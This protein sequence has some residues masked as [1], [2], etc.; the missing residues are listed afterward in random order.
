MTK[1][2]RRE[3]TKF[4]TKDNNSFIHP[5]ISYRLSDERRELIDRVNHCYRLGLTFK[6]IAQAI[7]TS[8]R[9]VYRLYFGYADCCLSC[10]QVEELKLIPGAMRYWTRTHTRL[11]VE[12]ET[13]TRRNVLKPIYTNTS[14]EIIPFEEL[15][16]SQ[17]MPLREITRKYIPSCPDR[18]FGKRGNEQESWEKV[19]IVE[20]TTECKGL[21]PYVVIYFGAACTISD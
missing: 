12:G 14:I 16:D 4:S 6:D 17:P 13:P 20:V 21:K 1:R 7:D 15:T 10:K 9:T 2:K 3:T 18:N 19:D 11:A 5:T 8:V